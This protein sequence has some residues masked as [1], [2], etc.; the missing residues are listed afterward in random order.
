VVI[1]AI[2]HS[3]G[4]G[5]SAYSQSVLLAPS[6]VPEV[7]SREVPKSMEPEDIERVVAAFARAANAAVAAGCDGVEVNIGQYSL[8]RQF[9]SGL[10]NHRGDAW[11]DRT[12][13]AH[14]VLAAVRS[15][16]P[17]SIVGIRFSADE[18]AP[19]AGLVP[20]AAAEIAVE[21]AE[22]VDYITVVRGSI[23]STAATRP[24]GHTEPG[25]NL[26]LA[27]QIREAVRS[28]H[29][30]RVNVFAQGSLV[31]WLPTA[32]A[33]QD[34]LADGAEMTRALIADAALVAKASAGEIERIRPCLLCNQTC[35]VRDA[36]NPIITCVVD[37]RSGHETTEEAAD[38]LANSS[39][40]GAPPTRIPPAATTAVTVLGGGIAGLEAARVAAMRGHT[41]TL[42]ERSAGLGG[43]VRTAALGAGRQR[44]GLI[45]D[46]LVAECERLGVDLRL[47]SEPA[48]FSGRVVV[49]TGARA[50]TPLV[51]VESGAPLMD[52]SAALRC[53]A[54]PG[55][56]VAVLDPIGGPVGVSVA[57][58][59]A[60][61]GESVHLVTP[62]QLAGN[63]L[64]RSG[65]LA[66]ANAR[67]QQLGVVIERRSILVGISGSCVLLED[68]FTGASRRLDVDLVI[69]AGYRVAN[70]EDF[71]QLTGVAGIDVV[72]A[73]DT[74]APRTI[75]EAML[76]ARRSVLALEGLL[77]V[78]DGVPMAYGHGSGGSAHV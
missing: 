18:L 11:G 55:R 22:L 1:A 50:G 7:N 47:N 38:F 10:T 45:A 29:G 19:W 23:Y 56:R 20:E 68:R 30:D 34:G 57:E 16:V 41:V 76:E 72:R 13:F 52:A 33:I 69:D 12:R 53:E 27:A 71:D 37:P 17:S 5:S 44:L 43:A 75:G 60:Q 63:E 77:P 65:D 26:D 40:E 9:L 67:L 78:S 35:Q 70:T 14:D 66:P 36:R 28:A 62:D 51:P 59:F 74:V 15:A 73:G 39:V 58:L 42:F 31:D 48:S 54:V 8:I 24:D 46:W 49:A 21:L 2:G 61:R 4:Q 64:S 3:G 32:A 6:S 25:F